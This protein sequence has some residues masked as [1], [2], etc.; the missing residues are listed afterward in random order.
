MALA[1]AEKAGF[2]CGLVNGENMCPMHR[3]CQCSA[4]RQIA[5]SQELQ[6]HGWV[7]SSPCTPVPWLQK[8][9]YNS[10]DPSQTLVSSGL[11]G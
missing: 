9:D 4:L 6:E 8:R 3:C 1:A 7:T 10:S 2:S 5:D 11:Y